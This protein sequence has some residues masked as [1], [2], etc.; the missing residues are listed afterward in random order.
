M[1]FLF[2]N[3]IEVLEEIT[4]MEARQLKKCV[5]PKVVRRHV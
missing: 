4:Q 3:Y 1:P 2:A 5:E